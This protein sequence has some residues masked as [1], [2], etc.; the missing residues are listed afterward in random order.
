[1]KNQKGEI[2]LMMLGFMFVIGLI[3]AEAHE[4]V[5]SDDCRQEIVCNV[6][7]K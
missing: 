4:Y 7:N 3:S 1:M 6:K 2:T 5:N